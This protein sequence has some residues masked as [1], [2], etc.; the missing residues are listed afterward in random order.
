[1]RFSL[2]DRRQNRSA[3]RSVA[4]R[5]QLQHTLERGSLEAL[6]LTDAAGIVIADSGDPAMCAELGAMAPLMMRAVGRLPESPL[7]RGADI[8]VR[9]MRLHGQELYLASAGGNVARDALLSDSVRG[10]ARI[11]ASN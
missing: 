2:S 3:D 11:L 4:L 7:L 6:V 10:V 8:Y 9:T 1:M 5:Y